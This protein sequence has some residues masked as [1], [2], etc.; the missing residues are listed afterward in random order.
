MR[1]ALMRG[2]D[3]DGVVARDDEAVMQWR[4]QLAPYLIYR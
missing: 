3:P 2:E 4:R 1:E